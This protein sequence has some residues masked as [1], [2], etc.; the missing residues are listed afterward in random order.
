MSVPQKGIDNKVEHPKHIIIDLKY[1]IDF[2]QL[3]NIP[4]IEFDAYSRYYIPTLMEEEG[5]NAPRVLA[6]NPDILNQLTFICQTAMVKDNSNTAEDNGDV[7]TEIFINHNKQLCA[8]VDWGNQYFELVKVPSFAIEDQKLCDK[9]NK[10]KII[11]IEFEVGCDSFIYDLKIYIKEVGLLA[12]V[13][14]YHDH[15]D[16]EFMDILS[17]YIENKFLSPAHPDRGRA[18]FEDGKGTI[19]L[20]DSKYVISCDSNY[21]YENDP[22]IFLVETLLSDLNSIFH[23]ITIKQAN[24]WLITNHSNHNLQFIEVPCTL[25]LSWITP[26]TIWLV[27]RTT[28]KDVCSFDEFIS[29]SRLIQYFKKPITSDIVETS[30]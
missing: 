22:K 25:N 15:E 10:Y 16:R 28:G 2:L 21:L 6:E 26:P 24:D 5:S 18:E 13:G 29:V 12:Y 8:A 30:Q 3:W 9:L 17:D 4:K 7:I 27:E 1:I 11:K 23:P 19:A 20:V 14:D